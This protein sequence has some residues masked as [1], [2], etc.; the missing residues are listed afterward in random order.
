MAK[1]IVLLIRKILC[2]AK[3][4]SLNVQTVLKR[5]IA[6]LLSKVVI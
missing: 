3:D 6:K 4:N 2:K 1:G 5:A